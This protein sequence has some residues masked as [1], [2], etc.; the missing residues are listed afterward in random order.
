MK[1][2]ENLFRELNNF[3]LFKIAIDRIIDTKYNDSPVFLEFI[4]Q[5]MVLIAL[6]MSNEEKDEVHKYLKEIKMIDENGDFKPY[7]VRGYLPRNPEDGSIGYPINE[8]SSFEDVINN[9]DEVRENLNE[10]IWD[11]LL[12]EIDDKEE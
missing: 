5:C 1:D 12:W 9:S 10:N 2:Y 3:E 8:D 7:I 11:K 6:K 4:Q